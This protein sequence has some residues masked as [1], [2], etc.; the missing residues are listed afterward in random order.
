M[1]DR[2]RQLAQHIIDGLNLEEIGVDD[3]D[4][5]APLFGEG[6]GLDSIDA[7]ELAVVVERHYGV[8]IQDMDEGRA[9]FAS[10]E[11]LDAYLQAKA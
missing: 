2:Q 10:I 6:L 7:L 1:D 4:P 8:T 5:A 9:A 11:A 3:I